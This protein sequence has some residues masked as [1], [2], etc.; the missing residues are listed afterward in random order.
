MIALGGTRVLSGAARLARTHPVITALASAV[1]GALIVLGVVAATS[2]SPGSAVVAAPPTGGSATASQPGGSGASK[3]PDAVSS[4]GLAARPQPDW[5]P[6]DPALAPVPAGTVHRVTWHIRD[7]VMPVAPGV[8][9]TMWTFDGRVPGPVLHGRV[10]DTFEVT[11]INDADMV[12][13]ID[14]HAEVG[15]PASVMQAVLPGRRVTYRFTAAHAGA[16]L[17]HC[18]TDPVLQHVGNGMYGAVIVDP[19]DLAPV[20]AQYVFVGSEFFFGPQGQPGDYSKMG[21]DAADAVVFNGYPYAY[22]H[23]PVR[24]PAGKNI[25]IWVVDAGPSRPIYFHVIGA[26]FSTVFLDGAYRLRPGDAGAG[27]G[28]T[29]PVDPGDGG[30]VELT[31]AGSGSYPFVTH[32]LSDARL[33]ATGSFV[34]S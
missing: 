17:Y 16:F 30:F 3:T 12:H 34:V 20:A 19:P 33:G 31:F 26:Q 9:Q 10:G 2:G 24:A 7:V 22:V 32:N 21:A 27:A 1:A 29:L 4:P 15:A 18:G 5:Q 13:S 28:Q 11:V 14:F 25:R 23:E 6:I 8:T